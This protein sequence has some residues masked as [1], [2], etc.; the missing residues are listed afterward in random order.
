MNT[1][2]TNE[3]SDFFIMFLLLLNS[4]IIYEDEVNG[5]DG[6]FLEN[7][8]I[9]PVFKTEYMFYNS[10]VR[11]A[12]SSIKYVKRFLANPLF[13]D[14]R[15]IIAG[16][17]T[18][19]NNLPSNSP[20]SHPG[21]PASPGLPLGRKRGGQL[22]NSNALYHVLYAAHNLKPRL[23]PVRPSRTLKVPSVILKTR[24]KDLISASKSELLENRAKLVQYLEVTMNSLL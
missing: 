9:Y 6:L 16:C 21:F 14:A 4:L 11:F 24:Q 7:V 8:P 10:F 5:V 22:G 17:L 19:L 1:I 12:Y 20:K 3:M 23:A 13:V 2:S 15:K 18:I